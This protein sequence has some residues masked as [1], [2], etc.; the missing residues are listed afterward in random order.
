MMKLLD[1]HRPVEGTGAPVD[2][3]A[4]IPEAK[5]RERRRHLAVAAAVL[6]IAGGTAAAVS[7]V[8][9]GSGGRP[10]T[11]SAPLDRPAGTGGP[12]ARVL[13][14]VR[15]VTASGTEATPHGLAIEGDRTYVTTFYQVAGPGNT[16]LSIIESDGSLGAHV[17]IIGDTI[18]PAVGDHAVWVVTSSG[19]SGAKQPG[20]GRLLRFEP[21]SLHLS[22]SVAVGDEATAVAAGLGAVWVAVRDELLDINPS[23]MRVVARRSFAGPINAL[24]VGSGSLW[25][26]DISPGQN[27]MTSVILRLDPHTLRKTASV[28]ISSANVYY[29][30]A[31]LHQIWTAYG[32]PRAHVVAVD[33]LTGKLLFNRLSFSVQEG[34]SGISSDGH[35]DLWYVTTGARVGRLGSTGLSSGTPVTLSLGTGVGLFPNLQ[36]QAM[37]ASLTE[38]DVA[39]GNR[40]VELQPLVQHAR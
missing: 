16:R 29:L 22:G 33:S 17:D 9:G 2:T 37:A 10:T 27:P 24:A 5:R 26:L 12:V 23:S 8:G 32:F 3:E 11:T 30:V 28:P 38:V 4:L 40:V 34:V 35:D 7:I 18:G 13:R 19:A 25:V 15:P 31:G 39:L 14:I 21:D 36:P 1:R 6:L 20:A